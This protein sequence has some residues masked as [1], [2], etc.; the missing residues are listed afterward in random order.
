[1]TINDHAVTV[2]PWNTPNTGHV[3]IHCEELDVSHVV[4]VDDAN[5]PDEIPAALRCDELIDAIDVAGGA[6]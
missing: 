4:H 3:L 6:K 2:E 1:M 5:W